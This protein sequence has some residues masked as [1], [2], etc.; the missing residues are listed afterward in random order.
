MKSLL[1][2]LLFGLLLFMSCRK[3][4]EFRPIKPDEPAPKEVT[5]FVKDQLIL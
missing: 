5:D 3:E 2:A 4:D 1:L